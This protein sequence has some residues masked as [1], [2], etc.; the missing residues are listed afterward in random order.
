MV[1]RFN[2]IP[3]K[4]PASYFVN[5]DR[6]VLKFLGRHKRPRIAN[7]ILKEKNKVGGWTLLDF[8]THYKA[9]LIRLWF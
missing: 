1:Y 8:K 5:T 2:T 3:V 4:I 9:T 6:L 7:M